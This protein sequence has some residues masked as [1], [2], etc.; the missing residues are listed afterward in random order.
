MNEYIAIF[1]ASG[2]ARETADIAYEMGLKPIFVTHDQAEVDHWGYSEEIILDSSIERCKDLKFIIGIGENAIRRRVVERY[3]GY[4]NFTNLIHPS[5][6]FGRGQIDRIDSKAGVIICAGARF[7]N[8]IEVGNF[9][10]FNLNVTV[11]HDAVIDEFTNIAPGVSISGNV[12][13]KTGC[14]VGTGAVINQGVTESK[15][16]IGADTIIG[17]GAVVVKSCD[18][19]A[20]YVGAPA[21]RIK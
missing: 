2:F 9:S 1:G 14:W 19:N 17:S 10:I 11:G 7:T 8:N 18:P 4:L 15:L 21:R 3:K 6:T 16:C 5:A 12:H 20:V 13:I